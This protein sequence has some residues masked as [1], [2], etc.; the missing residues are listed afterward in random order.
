MISD[1]REGQVIEW[2]YALAF[3]SVN[4]FGIIGGYFG[5]KSDEYRHMTNRL[6]C[7]IIYSVV[8]TFIGRQTGYIKAG[9]IEKLAENLFPFMNHRLWYFYCYIC[10]VL[11][12]PYINQFI[13]ILNRNS[14]FHLLILCFVC[15]S[16]IETLINRDPLGSINFG[17]SLCWL[18]YM[19]MWGAFIKLYLDNYEVNLALCIIA[20]IG[21][22]FF[23]VFSKYTIPKMGVLLYWDDRML[24]NYTSP[25]MVVSAL[26]AVLVFERT[27]NIGSN[28]LRKIFLLL[29][30]MAFGVYI[31]HCHPFILDNFVR[32]SEVWNHVFNANE[33]G[34]GHCDL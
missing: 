31:I 10:L 19:Y 15:F 1:S 11:L 32:D 29:S 16:V 27:V 25:F 8:F 13:K 30:Q 21:G 9:D 24:Y 22:T 28:L 12:K 20:G 34:G 33:H 4:I 6:F 5:I 14:Y 18:I 17:Y 7:V 3:S 2:I 23:T 26:C